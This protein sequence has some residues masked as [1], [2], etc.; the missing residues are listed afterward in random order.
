[1]DRKSSVDEECQELKNIKYKSVL[2]NTTNSTTISKVDNI[3]ML[4]EQ[5]SKLNKNDTWNR[6]DKTIKIKQLCD[7]VD[8]ISTEHKLSQEDIFDLKTYLELS[9][10]KKKLQCVK[11]IQYDKA[12]GR[13]KNIPSLHF[14]ALTRKFTLKKSEKRTSTLKSLGLGIHTHLKVD[15]KQQSIE[16]KK[17]KKIKNIKISPT[18]DNAS[19]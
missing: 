4:L 2:L 16:V 1:M 9:L 8:S 7:Y 3:E 14:N 19:S 6:I 15:V 12:T 10:D 5:E 18:N 17:S 13:I 11:D